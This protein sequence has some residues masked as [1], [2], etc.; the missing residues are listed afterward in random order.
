MRWLTRKV[1]DGGEQDAD[2]SVALAVK[3][4]SALLLLLLDLAL[5]R[6]KMSGDVWR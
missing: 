4:L 5:G 6:Q 1:G 3:L 2:V